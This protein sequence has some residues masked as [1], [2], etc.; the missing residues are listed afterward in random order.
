[1]KSLLQL[2]QRYAQFA[3]RAVGVGHRKVR[4]AIA[5]LLVSGRLQL[6]TSNTASQVGKILKP[7]ETLESVSTWADQ[8]KSDPAYKWSSA[9]HFINTP[10]WQCAFTP[11][12]DCAGDRCL[13]GAILNYTA[14]STDK[15]GEQQYEA[16]KFLDHFLGDIHQPLHVAFQSN[17]GGNTI[18]GTFLGESGNLH[19]V[20]KLYWF[21]FSR[22]S[23]K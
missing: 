5:F 19:H 15:T 13:Y 1:M 7:G 9:L 4:N 8:I 20:S 6:L 16:L 21:L 14:R 18:K 22:N 23:A 10:D 17:L 12:T 11:T 3:C 2:Q